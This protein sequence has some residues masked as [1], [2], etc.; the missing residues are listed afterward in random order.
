MQ[1]AEFVPWMDEVCRALCDT[2]LGGT[3]S[4]SGEQKSDR[5][6]PPDGD[7]RPHPKPKATAQRTDPVVLV[8]RIGEPPVEVPLAW[9][10]QS[11]RHCRSS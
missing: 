2:L 4:A 1:E 6:S 8:T 9:V 3:T 10:I 11:W 5:R 7:A